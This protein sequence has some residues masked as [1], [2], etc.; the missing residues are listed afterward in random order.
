M[1]CTAHNALTVAAP[2]LLDVLATIPDPRRAASVR[3]PLPAILGLAAS[4]LAANQQSVLAIAEWGVRQSPDDLRALGFSDGRTPCQSTLHRVFRKLDGALVATT[5]LTELQP[6]S[7]PPSTGL[8]GVGIDGKAHR[9]RGRITGGSVHELTAFCHDTGLVL[10]QMPIATMGEKADAELS[11]APALLDRL[12]WHGRVVT[13]DALFCQRALCQQ[14]RDAGGDYLLTVKANQ[15]ALHATI[16]D[17]FDPPPELARGARDVWPTA[18]TIDTGHGRRP[19]IREIVTSTGL[20]AWSDW[21]GLAQVFRMVHTWTER[22]T[23]KQAITYG[24]TSLNPDQGTPERL[25][26][27]KR[28]HWLIENRLHWRKDV[29][30]A[31][32]ASLIHVGQGPQVMAALRDIVISLFH[33]SGVRAIASRLRALSQSPT[34]AIAMVIRPLLTHA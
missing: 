31:E 12:D 26:A 6:L 22:G 7:S 11:V 16:R 1:E 28:G 8:Q 5:V 23:P 17:W 9:G 3:Y 30:F 10:G 21:P 18:R 27:L 20:T 4:A 33:A 19:D 29:T 32:D 34:D 2:S 13:G 15:P 25:L 24:I 14:V